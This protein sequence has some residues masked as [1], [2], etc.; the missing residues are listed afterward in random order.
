[1]DVGLSQLL[2]MFEHRLGPKLTSALVYLI[3]AG[4]A[5]LMIDAVAEHFV[6]PFYH[7]VIWIIGEERAQSLPYLVFNQLVRNR[8]DQPLKRLHRAFS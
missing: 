5:A 1:M 3:A 4:I 2:E 6:L 8:A 7:L